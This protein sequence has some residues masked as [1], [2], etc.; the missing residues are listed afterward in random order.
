MHAFCFFTLST[1]AVLRRANLSCQ[2]YIEK[3]DRESLLSGQPT[4]VRKR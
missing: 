2:L 1:Q 3:K 4:K